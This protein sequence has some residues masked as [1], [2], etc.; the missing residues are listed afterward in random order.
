MSASQGIRCHDCGSLNEPGAS[1]CAQCSRALVPLG[2]TG[3]DNPAVSVRSISEESKITVPDSADDAPQ[4]NSPGSPARLVK[5]ERQAPDWGLFP[6]Q[7]CGEVIDVEQPSQGPPDFNLPSFLARS[8]WLVAFLACPLVLLREVMEH[9]GAGSLILC[10]AGLLLLFR[11]LNP[12]SFLALVHLFRE[13]S[14]FGR[15]NPPQIQRFCFHLRNS[16]GR[17][18][19]VRVKGLLTRGDIRPGDRLSIWGQWRDGVLMLKRAYNGRTKS[20]VLLRPNYSWLSLALTVATLAFV[21]ASFY[22]PVLRLLESLRHLA[23]LEGR[24]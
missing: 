14:P 13:L 11:L 15:P 5:S 3:C 17:E 21:F 19:I 1:V 18:H 8:L 12:L 2:P 10:V 24:P 20:W 16:E 22:Q 23:Q 9:L 7:V 6:C 4:P